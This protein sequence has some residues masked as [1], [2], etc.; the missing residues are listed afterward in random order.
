MDV[1][2]LMLMLVWVRCWRHGGHRGYFSRII[3]VGLVLPDYL[4]SCVLRFAYFVLRFS[5]IGLFRRSSWITS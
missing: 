5:K 2:V 4:V 1:G 3:I